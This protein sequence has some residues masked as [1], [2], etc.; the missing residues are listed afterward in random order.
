MTVKHFVAVLAIALLV[1]GGAIAF[2]TIGSGIAF[3]QGG[4][5]NSGPI[6]GDALDKARAAA[7]AYT[8]GGQA[9][10]TEIDDEE[11]Y[12]E[13]E[14]VLAD[15]RQVDVHL[16]RDFNVLNSQG[17]RDAPNDASDK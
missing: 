5:D 12:Y 2:T 10:E 6:I 3:A 15:G 16:D 7:L 17:D 13:V 8:G 9:T 1:I 4:S 14:V 11:G